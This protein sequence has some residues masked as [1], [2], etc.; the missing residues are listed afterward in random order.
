MRRLFLCLPIKRLSEKGISGMRIFVIPSWYPNK[1]DKINGS[2]FREQSLALYR[3][4]VNTVVLNGTFLPRSMYFSEDSFHY[5]HYSDEGLDVY[6]INLDNFG[7]VRFTT[8]G[9]LVSKFVY[10]KLFNEAVKAGQ[11][12]IILA[13]SFYPGGAIACWLGKK[14]GIPVFVIEHSS[15]V[16]KN[17]M[18]S[19]RRELL[20]KTTEEAAQFLCVSEFL[21]RQIIGILHSNKENMGVSPNFV[22]DDFFLPIEKNVIEPCENVAFVAVGS[23]IPQKNQMLIVQAFCKAFSKTDRVTL[24]LVG[25]GPEREMIENYIRTENRQCQ[26]YLKGKIERD[27]ILA[28]YQNADCFIHASKIET[29]GVVYIEAMACGLPII[30]CKNGGSDTLINASNGV[31]IENAT[32]DGFATALSNFVAGQYD[33]N[34]KRI[35]TDCR[36]KYSESSVVKQLLERFEDIIYGQKI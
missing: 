26:I 4:K 10:R 27:K 14:Y 16:A 17:Q 33:F 32:V 21:K 23:L 13:H 29:F 11:P 25:D 28:E 19:Y 20:K 30:T 7:I 6:Q 5:K 9:M 36:N 34:R 31:L 3:A 1:K 15:R 2:F 12:D 24:T 8:L 18:S 22:S 35:Q